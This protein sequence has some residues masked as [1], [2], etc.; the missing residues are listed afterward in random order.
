VERIVKKGGWIA[1]MEWKK[2]EMKSGPPLKERM[3]LKDVEKLVAKL[4]LPI[5]AR[6]LIAGTRYLILVEK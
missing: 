6:R 2:E 3:A 1:I 4:G 5:R